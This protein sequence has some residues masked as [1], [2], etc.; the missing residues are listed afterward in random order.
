MG[1]GLKEGQTKNGEP[2]FS[3]TPKPHASSLCRGGGDVGRRT[4]H[5]HRKPEVP[6]A[7]ESDP[8]PRDF[9]LRMDCEPDVRPKPRS[10]SSN[11]N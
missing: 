4:S 8:E 7:E 10:L 11:R 1:W 9:T 6:I 2:G 5:G 3:L